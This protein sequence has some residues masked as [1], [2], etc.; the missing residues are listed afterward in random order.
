MKGK[1]ADGDEQEEEDGERAQQA[2]EDA[3]W[4]S[5]DGHS[6]KVQ[7]KVQ[8]QANGRSNCRRSLS[9]SLKA[10]SVRCSFSLHKSTLHVV[11]KTARGVRLW[12]LVID[13]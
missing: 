4:S 1:G 6:R 11:V 12:M 13:R 8:C 9:H 2:S 3:G 5:G 10:L 7:Q